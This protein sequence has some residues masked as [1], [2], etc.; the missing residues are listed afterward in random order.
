MITDTPENAD[1]VGQFLE[2][3]GITQWWPSGGAA[4]AREGYGQVL[5][6]VP[7]PLLAALFTRPGVTW[8]EL[9]VPSIPAMATATEEVSWGAVKEWSEGVK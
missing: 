7:V 3:H 5:A 4:G 8:A 6:C 2:E 1:A 9:E